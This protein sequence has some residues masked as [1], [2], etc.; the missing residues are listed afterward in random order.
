MPKQFVLFEGNLPAKKFGILCGIHE[1]F[2]PQ[3]IEEYYDPFEFLVVDIYVLNKSIRS[4]N[5]VGPQ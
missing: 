1:D 5:G 4:M 2:N 3:L